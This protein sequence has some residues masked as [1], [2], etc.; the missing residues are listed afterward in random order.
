MGQTSVLIH[1]FGEKKGC[2]SQ[3]NLGNTESYNQSLQ[4]IHNTQEHVKVLRSFLVKKSVL[5]LPGDTLYKN[6][7]MPRTW[8]CSLLQEDSICHRAT[9]PVYHNPRS[10]TL[11]PSSH[12]GSPCA[13]EPMLHNKRNHHTKK[14]KPATTREQPPFSTTRENPRVD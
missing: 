5:D 2:P 3:I 4:E 13:L 10:H 7:P 8:V 14:P 6:P 11:E 1:V 12:N 9:K